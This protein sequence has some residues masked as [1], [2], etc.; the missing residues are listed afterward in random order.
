LLFT[1]DDRAKGHHDVAM[2]DQ[3]GKTL[4]RRRLPEAA[5]TITRSRELA[6]SSRGEDS[7]PDPA[8]VTV[9][10]QT[11]RGPWAKAPAATGYRVCPEQASRHKETIANPGK[12]DDFFDA[13]DL[14]D[15]GRSR[16]HQIREPAAD[17]DIAKAAKTAA[18]AHQ[19]LIRQHTRHQLRTR[20]AAREYSPAALAACKDPGL[21][22]KDTHKP[23]AKAPDPEPAAK[24]TTAQATTALKQARQ[25]GNLQEQ[26]RQIQAARRAPHPAQ[27][28]VIAEAHAASVQPAAA[29]TTTLNQQAKNTE[30]RVSRL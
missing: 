17:S 20:P 8:Q 15:T 19:K 1:G 29:A 30:T 28:D 27:P 6:A 22:G 24:L 21:T 12:N 11:G 13:Q 14:A 9:V 7:E 16:R 3:A 23:L 4:A 10:L 26:A 18:R 5:E 25:R 2:Q